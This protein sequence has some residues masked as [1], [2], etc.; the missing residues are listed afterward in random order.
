M[1]LGHIGLP[2][3]DIQTSKKFYDAIAPYIGLKCIDI[4]DDFVGYGSKHSYEFYI[5]T[6][7]PAISGIHMCFEVDTKE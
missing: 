7:R 6:G 2:V 3:Q 1:T 4:Y 5:H